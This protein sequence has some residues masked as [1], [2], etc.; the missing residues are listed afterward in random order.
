MDLPFFTEEHRIFRRAAPAGDRPDRPSLLAVKL[1]GYN[2]IAM[3]KKSAEKELEAYL[4]RLKVGDVL[5]ASHLAR[6]KG[7]GRLEDQ[8]VVS[9]YTVQEVYTFCE[10]N[11]PREEVRTVVRPYRSRSAFY[12]AFWRSSSAIAWISVSVPRISAHPYQKA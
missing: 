4:D 6:K 7:M 11:F 12:G 5:E 10:E 3:G 8:G 2:P 1:P 9:L